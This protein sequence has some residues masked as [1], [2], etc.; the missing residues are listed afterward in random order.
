MDGKVAGLTGSRMIMTFILRY[1]GDQML[2]VFCCLA[3]VEHSRCV[4]LQPMAA[5]LNHTIFL[6]EKVLSVSEWYQFVEH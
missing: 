6:E 5:S 4:T 3:T 1:E 2:Q